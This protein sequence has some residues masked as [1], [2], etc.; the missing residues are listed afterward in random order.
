MEG[1]DALDFSNG[2]EISNLTEEEYDSLV[3]RIRRF[4]IKNICTKDQCNKSILDR[5]FDGKLRSM[6][7]NYAVN[8]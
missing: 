2:L 6:L 5:T 4:L 8:E 3:K 7:N 1:L